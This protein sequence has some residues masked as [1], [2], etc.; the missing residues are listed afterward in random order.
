MDLR[1]WIM[2]INESVTED[3]NVCSILD[4]HNLSPERDQMAEYTYNAEDASLTHWGR[5]TTAAIFQTTFSN[6]F[7]WMKMY[8]Y[9]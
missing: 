5:D 7:S 6:A 8:K 1:D 3:H 4:L 2:Q 9:D